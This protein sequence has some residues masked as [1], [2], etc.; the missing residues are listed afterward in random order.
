MQSKFDTAIRCAKRNRFQVLRASMIGVISIACLP[1]AALPAWSG[2][3]VTGAISKPGKPAEAT[4]TQ[5]DAGTPAVVVDDKKVESLLGKNIKSRAGENLGQIVDVLIT[6]DGQLRAAVIDFGGF[7]GVGTRKVAV[8]WSTL[9]FADQKPVL[10]MTADEL[11]VAPE[12]KSGQP[13]VIVGSAA[14]D[15]TSPNQAQPKQAPPAPA[16]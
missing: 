14:K 10:S 16:K 15:Q 7:L 11:R 12:F 3:P 9:R 5:A 8:A 1:F 2:A 13:I 6:G 4:N